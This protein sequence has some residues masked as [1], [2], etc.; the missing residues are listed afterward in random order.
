M[1]SGRS[2]DGQGIEPDI[3]VAEESTSGQ[4]TLPPG[5]DPVLQAALRAFRGGEIAGG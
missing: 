2:F 1:P 3:P 4:A 5:E